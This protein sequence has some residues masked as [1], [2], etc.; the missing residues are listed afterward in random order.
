MNYEDFID[1][2]QDS[3]PLASFSSQLKALWYEKKGEWDKA[4]NLVDPSDDP[5]DKHIHAYLHRKEGDKWNANYW[6]Q[7]S[8]R[9]YPAFTLDE[10]WEELVKD[11]L[12]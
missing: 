9:S 3:S 7:R 4:H 12:S 2:L 6:Y 10:E 8:G 1:S 11:N 5:K